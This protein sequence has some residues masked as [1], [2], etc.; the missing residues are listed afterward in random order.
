MNRGQMMRG[1]LMIVILIVCSRDA[2]A[3]VRRYQ[4]STQPISPYL[5]L[6]R[7]EGALPNYYALVRPLEEQRRLERNVSDFERRQVLVNR[8]LEQKLG[9]PAGIIPTGTAGR[10]MTDSQNQTGS[11]YLNSR[12]YF[13]QF[14][15]R[16][17][18]RRR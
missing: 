17:D 14:Q 18:R 4:P 2:A 10:F 8:E 1:L 13:N 6:L 11:A 12:R 15:T 7:P 5:N 3:Q 9:Q 16:L